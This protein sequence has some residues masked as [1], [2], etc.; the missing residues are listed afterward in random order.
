MKR[1]GR[2]D[3]FWADDCIEV[4]IYRMLGGQEIA[5]PLINVAKLTSLHLRIKER[6]S[7][8]I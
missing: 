6:Y 2:L 4:A 7:S 8:L 5:T 3:F 1:Y